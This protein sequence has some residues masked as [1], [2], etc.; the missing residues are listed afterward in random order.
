MVLQCISTIE[1]LSAFLAAIASLAPMNQTMLIEHR[2]RKESLIA[3]GA[4]EGTLARVALSN[5]IVEIR[6]NRKLASATL[7]GTFEWLNALMKAKMLP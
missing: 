5:V 6:T 4:Q 3:D 2:A 1:T 7:L